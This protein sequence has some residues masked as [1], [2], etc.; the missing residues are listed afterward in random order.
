[1]RELRILINF[2]KNYSEVQK[3]SSSILSDKGNYFDTHINPLKDLI[4]VANC[5]EST[6]EIVLIKRNI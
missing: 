5:K 2:I 6:N 1:M 3:Q 4:S